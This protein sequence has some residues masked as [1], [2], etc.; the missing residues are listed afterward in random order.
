MSVTRR[1]SDR[2][3][4]RGSAP[5]R[6]LAA[7][8]LLAGIGLAF[9][10]GEAEEATAASADAA[11]SARAEKAADLERRLDDLEAQVT[12]LQA[13]LERLRGSGAVVTTA[14]LEKRIEALSREI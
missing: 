2:S 8:A 4:A 13:E 5:P 7:F 12:A 10:S 6:A 14:E 9:G 1:P 3:V 11:S